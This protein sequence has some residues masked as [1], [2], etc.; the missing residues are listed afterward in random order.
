MYYETS[1]KDFIIRPATEEDIS[2]VLDMIH[3]LAVYEHM[4]DQAIATAEGIREAV[5]V[6]Q[7]TGILIGEYCGE[8]VGYALYFTS[9]STF[10]GRNGIYLEDLYIRQDMRHRGFGKAMLARLA[11]LAVE[12]GYGRLEWSCLDWNQPSIDFYLSLKAEPLSEWTMYRLTG[13]S[14]TEMAKRV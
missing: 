3:E 12:Q 9:F 6:K 5:F 2:F 1:V 8:K 7:N 11:A 4:E 14:L 13:K 10:L